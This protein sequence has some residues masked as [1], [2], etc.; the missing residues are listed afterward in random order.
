MDLLIPIKRALISVSDKTGIVEL[1]QSLADAGCEIISTGGTQRKLEEAGITTTEISTVTGNPEAFGGRMKTISFNIESALLFDREKDAE[2]AAALNIEPIDLVVCNL[3]PFQ[4][5]LKKGADFETLI[6]NIDIGGP[7]MIRAA[8]KNFKYVATVTQPSDY[9]ELMVQLKSHKGALTYDF[10]KKLMTKA[11][12][13]TA[14]YDALIAT[15][16][17]KEIGVNS[18]RLGFEEG[19]DLRYGENSHQAARFYKEKNADNSLY[20]LN[21]LH[22]KALS[23]NNILDINGAIEAIKESTRPACSVIKHSNPCGLCEGDDQ[24]ELLQ[25]AWAGDPIS[26]FGSIIA[27]NKKVTFETVQ[28]FELNNEDKSKRKFVEVVIAPAF[29]PEAL[30]YLQQHKN[31]RI[32]EFDAASLTGHMDLRYMNGSLLA[33]DTDNELHN[34]LDVV[35]EAPVDMEVEQPLIEFG[36]RAIKTIKSNSIAIVR[37]KNG[38]A[39]LLGMG[40][41]QPNRLI[42]TKLSIEKSRENLR[43]E[44]TGAAEDF[45]AYV[46]EELANAWLISDAF[47]PFAD[48]VEIA[49]AAGIRKI[50]QPG[51]SIRDKSVI[52]TCNDLGVSMVFTGIRHFKH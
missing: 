39:Q 6:E 22:G 33:Q 42:A 30:V 26:A 52:A 47:F 5:V 32:I 45:E 46:A 11:F 41:G 4:E 43:N 14:D 50:V 7:T 21:V 51:G 17:D 34:K 44:Y 20:D 8:A 28:F 49:A 19:I 35:T 2:E 37:F 40:A 31:L 24:A 13:H 1:A 27:F 36:L 23:F 15:T 12:N 18:L 9:T 29:T 25:L 38:Y 10:R 3:Y 48:N 16:M